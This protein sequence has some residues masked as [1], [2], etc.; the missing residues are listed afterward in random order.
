MPDPEPTSPSPF[1]T[2]LPP[3]TPSAILPST[4]PTPSHG[5]G[6]SFTLACST[7][8][9]ASPAACLAATLKPATWP[10][11]NPFCPRATIT[12]FPSP[13]PAIPGGLADL[14]PAVDAKDALV[15]GT[16]VML[17]VHM[18]LGAN[19]TN[20]QGILV[21]RLEELADGDGRRGFR[22]A[23]KAEGFP[24]FLLRSER[25]QEFV[26]VEAPEYIEV[27]GGK[28][29]GYF[30]WE[31]FYGVLA[32][33]VRLGVGS[34]LETAFGAWMHGLKRFVEEGW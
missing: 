5:P 12:D 24:G 8:I 32:P 21:T 30:C 23:W 26:E 3:N 10:Q 34:R 6:G 16:K 27:E 17:D 13:P 33:V 4:L 31:T 9:Y 18:G 19:P 15:P 2:L 28:A 14:G 25:V 11:W 22:V 20:R 29:C 7:V 1:P